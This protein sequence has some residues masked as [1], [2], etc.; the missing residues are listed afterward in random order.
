MGVTFRYCKEC[1]ECYHED[2]FI[3]CNDC[4][5]WICDDCCDSDIDEDEERII[6]DCPMCK[7]QLISNTNR[8]LLTNFIKLLEISEINKTELVRLINLIK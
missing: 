6:K 2:C 1:K 3:N 8:K 7:K 4:N 5:N